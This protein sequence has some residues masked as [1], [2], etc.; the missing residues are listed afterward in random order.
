M[1]LSLGA[2]AGVVISLPTHNQE[3][4]PPPEYQSDVGS[5][6]PPLVGWQD[7]T[8][9]GFATLI[10]R[11]MDGDFIWFTDRQCWG[12]WDAELRLWVIESPKCDIAEKRIAQ[13]LAQEIAYLDTQNLTDE[14]YAKNLRMWKKQIKTNTYQLNAIAMT[15]A[16]PGIAR[17]GIEFDRKPLIATPTC[18]YELPSLKKR[19]IHRD[20]MISKQIA[21]D[22]KPGDCPRW[23]QFI[24]EVCC[25]DDELM[26]YL[27]CLAGYLMTPW[28]NEPSIFLC[29][30]QGGNGKTI[31]FSIMSELLGG[32][33][34]NKSYAH[35]IGK[36]SI[37]SKNNENKDWA[38]PCMEGIRL[39]IVAET[40]QSDNLNDGKLKNLTGG[41]AM[42]AEVKY[43]N[44][45]N[46][47]PCAKWVIYSNHKL[48]I[49][50][51]TQG[52]WR[53]AR[54]IPW[55]YQVPTE[56]MIPKDD[57]LAIL[58]SELPQIT[59]WAFDGLRQYIELGQR[60][61]TCKIVDTS[62][63]EYRANEDTV[64]KFI[65]SATGFIN[66][67]SPPK[68]KD[69]FAEF[70]KWCEEEGIKPFGRHAFDEA[71]P[72]HGLHIVTKGGGYT[73]IEA[74]LPLSLLGED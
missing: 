23:M 62:T 37:I 69:Y 35:G 25:G 4:E 59:Q 64:G 44:P 56:K 61:P 19:Q 65:A 40:G 48:R 31:F 20:D 47:N 30:G 18:V 41:D 58:R 34:T 38:L 13:Q 51:N 32:I 26:V 43:G 63:T 29:Y 9:Q 49:K 70:K 66:P 24:E 14:D 73:Y 71:L 67:T 6:H 54:H 46:F 3:P 36:S 7:L 55:L 72:Q 57:F 15:Q 60:M 45:F 16:M 10:H 50:D 22:P 2:S 12:H 68:A 5:L 27:Q 33:L 52:I 8:Q 11:I 53:R 28:I 17:Q 21:V 74:E 1:L 39:A 42:E